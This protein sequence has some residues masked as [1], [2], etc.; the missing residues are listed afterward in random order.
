[1]NLPLGLVI[2]AV[3]VI[4]AFFLIHALAR[5]LDRLEEAVARIAEKVPL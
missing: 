1:M 2:V 4:I 3:A 5:R